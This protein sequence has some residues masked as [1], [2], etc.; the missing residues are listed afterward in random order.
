MADGNLADGAA[1]A[2]ARWWNT[3]IQVNQTQ[4]CDQMGH[5]VDMRWETVKYINTVFPA[6]SD[7]LGTW[8]KCHCNQIVAV[9]RGVLLTNA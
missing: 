7:T 6:Y 9:S 5:P 3:E 4:P 1:I 8:E 2:I